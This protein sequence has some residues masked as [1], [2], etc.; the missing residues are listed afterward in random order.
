T[1]VGGTVAGAVVASALAAGHPS[2]PLYLLL[3][4]AFAAAGFA[5]FGVN[6]GVYSATI[7]AYV[8]FLLALAGSPEHEAALDRVGAT[9]LGGALAVAVYALW[10]TWSR[11]RVPL[12]LA[13]LLDAQRRYATRLLHAFLAADEAAAAALRNAQIAAWLARSNA[14]ASVD[15]MGNEPVRPKAVTVRAALAILAAS[16]RF[17]VAALTLQ[18]RLERTARLPDCARPALGVLADHLDAA[19]ET[20]AGALRRRADPLPLPPLR[21]AQIALKR[22]LDLQPDAQLGALVSETDLMVDA[23]NT[24]AEVLHRLR[25]EGG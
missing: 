11:A 23:L 19:L 3:A 4:V 17:G 9:V 24:M 18:A 12:D 2:D 7:T 13:E 25:A 6:Y 15:A 10:P 22:A 1:R 5:L 20:M 8:V 14:E 21:E 16:R